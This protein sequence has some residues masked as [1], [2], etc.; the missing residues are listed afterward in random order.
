MMTVSRASASGCLDRTVADKAGVP[1]S[2]N[3]LLNICVL[4]RD[5]VVLREHGLT[6]RRT[7]KPKY[8]KNMEE[9]LGETPPPP[10]SPTS[11]TYVAGPRLG[12]TQRPD[13]ELQTPSKPSAVKK[14]NRASMI[15]VM[16]GLGVPGM[17]PPPSPTTAARSP[18]S[19]SF[20]AKSKRNYNFFGHRPS[21]ELIADNVE[22]YFPSAKKRELEKT[23]RHSML[24]M[25]MGPNAYRKSVASIAPSERVSLDSERRPSVEK[26]PPSRRPTSR[27]TSFAASP[28]TET[29]PEETEVLD[30]NVPRVAVTSEGSPMRLPRSSGESDRASLASV[31][32]RPALLPPFEHGHSKTSNDA[33]HT[34][35]GR[36]HLIQQHS[37][38][39]SSKPRPK[40]ILQAR[41]GSAGSS[42]SRMSMLSQL[43]KNRDRGDTASMLTVDEI[44][45]EVEHRRASTIFFDDESDEEVDRSSLRVP[46]M[47]DPGVP[48]SGV[49]EEEEES[50]EYESSGFDEDDELEDE[51]EEDK[52]H[53]KAVFSTGCRS[54]P[55]P[56]RGHAMQTHQA[57]CPQ[58][59]PQSNGSRVPSLVPALLDPS[60]SA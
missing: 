33:P 34:T 21:S 23:L 42:R 10:M 22:H 27:T 39:G 24:R 50:E 11:P 20:L 55:P 35:E 9:F 1:L 12:I 26:T 8:R 19:G 18:S 51:D 13:S 40:S 31:D 14:M 17:N 47:A 3:A 45:A 37:M 25:S 2:E 46:S 60:F 57:D 38:P 52:D 49:E 56:S 41:R 15:S 28:P 4:H 53:G 30:N 54:P 7:R 58:P 48:T 36:P 16:S 29:I 6:L 5:G 44:T 43:R 59:N 32:S